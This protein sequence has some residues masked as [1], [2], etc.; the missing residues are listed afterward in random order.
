[1]QRPLPCQKRRAEEQDIGHGWLR[2]PSHAIRRC[3]FLSGMQHDAFMFFGL[4]SPL[5]RRTTF[6]DD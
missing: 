3:S 2:Y 1:S 5:R 6:K 4:A